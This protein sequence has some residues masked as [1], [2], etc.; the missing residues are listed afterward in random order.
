M[1]PVR[2]IVFF[3]FIQEVKHAKT[4]VKHAT[5]DI[6]YATCNIS[7]EICNLPCKSMQGRRQT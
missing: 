5:I 2:I 6:K 4:K 7:H 1:K 3:G